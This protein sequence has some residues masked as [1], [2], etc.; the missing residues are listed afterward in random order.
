MAAAATASANGVVELTQDNFKDK[1]KGK[2]AFVK[3]F[4]PW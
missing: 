4:A 1:V 3:F 2:N